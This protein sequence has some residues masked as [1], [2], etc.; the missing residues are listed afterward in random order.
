MAGGAE[1]SGGLTGPGSSLGSYLSLSTLTAA[2]AEELAL[3]GCGGVEAAPGA[4]AQMAPPKWPCPVRGSGEGP[5]ARSPHHGQ[6]H[7]D[8]GQHAGPEQ[9]LLREVAAQL[10]DDQ[11][12][13]H[14]DQTERVEV[15]MGE[16]REGRLD[17]GQPPK[18]GTS[19]LAFGGQG[20]SAEKA[21]QHLQA[22]GSLP[23]LPAVTASGWV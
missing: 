12:L 22:P 20:P 3:G 16:A 19:R 18:Q 11:A 4:Q 6:S 14:L 21:P 7:R 23:T 15:G 8:E 13:G 9:H 10:S 1:L 17:C 2:P 5:K